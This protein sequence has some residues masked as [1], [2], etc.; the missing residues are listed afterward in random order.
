MGWFMGDD[1]DD[2]T[3]DH[4]GYVQAVVRDG[5]GWRDL[6]LDDVRDDSRLI[7]VQVACDCGWRSRRMTAPL[8]AYWA[9]CI[10][11]FPREEHEDAARSIW[12]DHRR[13]VGSRSDLWQRAL[14]LRHTVSP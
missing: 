3:Y 11:I 4:E 7:Q 2:E 8:G 13:D 12:E 5:F 10:V 9:P 1:H 6:G 14:D